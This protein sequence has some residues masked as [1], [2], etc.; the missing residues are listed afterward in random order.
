MHICPRGSLE[1]TVGLTTLMEQG[2]TSP[3]VPALRWMSSP[4]ISA[5]PASPSPPS[6]G[7]IPSPRCHPARLR[8]SPI[9]FPQGIKGERGHTGSPGE[10]G[11]SVSIADQPPATSEPLR[12]SVP[13][14]K[15]AM[16]VERRVQ[17]PGRDHVS[18]Q[19]HRWVFHEGGQA[20]GQQ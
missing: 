15:P 14:P 10:K 18:F 12:K 8:P 13:F 17:C 6:P 19:C 2:H 9:F 4:A 11:E 5:L 3:K 1:C 7:D 20:Y 16:S